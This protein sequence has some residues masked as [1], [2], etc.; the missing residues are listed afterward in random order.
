MSVTQESAVL[1]GGRWTPSL[2]GQTVPVISPGKDVPNGC[3]K[4]D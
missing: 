1:I 4:G 2:D 3:L